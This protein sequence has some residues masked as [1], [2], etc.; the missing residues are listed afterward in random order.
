MSDY[1]EHDKLV[2]I[3]DKSQVIGSFI[4]WLENEKEIRLCTFV[5]AR[6]EDRIWIA[7]GYT[8]INE[9][10]ND[11]LAEFFNIDQNKINQEKENMIKKLQELKSH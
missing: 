11:L 6:R 2:A 8:P 5:P 1:P 4:E 9:S 10:I 7:E 3:S